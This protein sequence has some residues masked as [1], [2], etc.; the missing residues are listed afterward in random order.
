MSVLSTTTTILSVSL[1]LS[2]HPPGNMIHNV[3]YNVTI[4]E[5]DERPAD[6]GGN[7]K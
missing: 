6:V 4:R 7:M 1:G 2:Y 5:V 3:I